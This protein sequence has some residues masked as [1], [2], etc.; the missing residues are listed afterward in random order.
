MIIMIIIIVNIIDI[1]HHFV[2]SLV[3]SNLNSNSN[4]YYIEQCMT[5]IIDEIQ[6]CSEQAVQ[7]WNLNHSYFVP[8]RLSTC[9]AN[10]EVYECFI[11]AALVS[12]LTN[13]FLSKSNSIDLSINQRLDVHCLNFRQSLTI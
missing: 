13:S 1:H 7:N 11:Q 6:P 10:W 3:E 9:C 4:Y 8:S 2:V 5:K 12:V